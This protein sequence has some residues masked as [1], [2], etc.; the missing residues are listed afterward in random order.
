MT[1]ER[2]RD[3]LRVRDF[4]FCKEKMSEALTLSEGF[5]EMKDS[6]K[7]KVKSELEALNTKIS[8]GSKNLSENS[9]TNEILSQLQNKELN[10]LKNSL[11]RNTAIQM[12]L[13]ELNYNVWT[14]D[15]IYGNQTWQAVKQFQ[16]N[17]NVG[18][19]KK[20]NGEFDGIAGKETMEK[21]LEKNLTKWEEK[22]SQKNKEKSDKK[23]EK[24]DKNPSER[25]EI[26]RDGK[27]YKVII[28]DNF[29]S[30]P[31]DYKWKDQQ[32]VYNI[33]DPLNKNK[34]YRFYYN[35]QCRSP[36]D[37]RNYPSKI[38]IDR[39]K[40]RWVKNNDIEWAA[41]TAIEMLGRRGNLTLNDGKNSYQLSL[42]SNNN[43]EII[44]QTSLNDTKI[45]TS[46]VSLKSFIQ[47]WG[48]IHW[49]Y[50]DHV[51]LPQMK[52]Q[53]KKKIKIE[54]IQKAIK[55]KL[56]GKERS[57]TDIFWQ[58]F[59]NN[60][61]QTEKINNYFKNQSNNQ[62]ITVS[63]DWSW[64]ENI[65]LSIKNNKYN[66]NIK[67]ITSN[68]KYNEDKVRRKLKDI[69]INEINPPKTQ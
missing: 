40:T 57:K 52:A 61:G 59:E 15:G 26:G 7:K 21:M 27:E 32:T 65:I 10:E 44:L 46:P 18:G 66:I 9:T 11:L 20:I 58:E 24:N 60:P 30:L 36:Y 41:A 5:K 12:K 62:N 2:I 67:D 51:I 23:A 29:D 64:N 1:F 25:K 49:E 28:L 56:E 45:E 37:N 33:I 42:I 17:N 38:I 35:G 3:I 54:N 22:A 19:S 31:K 34:I 50:W 48:N 55:S 8:K 69:I 63:I 16:N 53:L 6:I 47:K 13:K 68:E 43:N 14:I 4:I 39:I